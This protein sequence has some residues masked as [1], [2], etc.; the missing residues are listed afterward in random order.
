MTVSKLSYAAASPAGSGT[1]VVPTASGAIRRPPNLENLLTMGT[2]HYLHAPACPHCG[3][4]Q[5][6]VI[7]LGKSSQGWCYGLHVRP[8]W[9]IHTFND[10]GAMITD[11][12]QDRWQIKD[13]HGT[14]LSKG[15]WEEIVTKREWEKTRTTHD[16]FPRNHAI[17]G[18][19]GLARCAIDDWHC[20]GHGEGTY[21]YIIGDFS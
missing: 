21:D 12:I 20:I 4:E 8:E 10:V 18:P 19:N 17:K 15:Q 2:N 11:K 9:G 7:H 14:A 5:E 3:K 6:D 13:E 1:I 16:W